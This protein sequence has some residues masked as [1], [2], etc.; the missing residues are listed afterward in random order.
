MN[1]PLRTA[2]VPALE[3]IPGLVHGFE[4][5][6]GIGG[7]S[8]DDSRRRVA[9][10]LA[11]QGRLLLLR[12]VHGA[13]VRTAPWDDEFPEGDAA[14]GGAPGLLLGIETADCLP[15]LLVDP[16]RRLV[17]AV[18]A[19]WRGTVAGVA[20]AAVQALSARGSRPGDLIAALGPAIGVCCYE[21]GDELRPPFDAAFGATSASFFVRG[22]R[23]RAHLDVRA[24]NVVQLAGAGL[25]PERLHHVADCTRC[26]ADLYPSYRR[27]GAGAG[28]L[29]SFI[30]WQ[31]P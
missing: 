20:R 11:P 3:A 27:D 12:Q 5:P 21:V 9:A 15:V 29:L 25:L 2:R 4:Q 10:A 28:R 31:R 7:E 13:A 16:R 22:P 26:R 8:R 17:A 30:G 18:H 19:G 24:A 14:V 23:G 6:A 1:T